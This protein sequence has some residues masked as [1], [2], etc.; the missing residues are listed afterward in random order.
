MPAMMGTVRSEP[1][2]GAIG[3]VDIRSVDP[4]PYTRFLREFA[5]AEG[6]ALADI[7]ARWERLADLGLPYVTLLAN[8]INHPDDRGHF[9]AAE[10][11]A[12]CIAKTPP[13]N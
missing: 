6:I 11:L 9:L 13:E 10:E 2:I 4:R 3:A 5:A 7:S 8:G 1:A 12:R